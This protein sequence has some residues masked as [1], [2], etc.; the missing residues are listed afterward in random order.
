[1]TD[2]PVKKYFAVAVSA[3]VNRPLTYLPPDES[4]QPLIQ[5][6]RVLVPLSGRKITGYILGMVDSAPVGQQ[7][8][9]IYAVLDSEPFFPAEQ[10]SFY[11][12]IA[13]Y[14]HYP[15]GE[16]IKTA[17]PAGLTKKSGRRVMITDAGRKYLH[18]LSER[19]ITGTPWFSGLLHKGE[20]SPHVTGNLWR[21]KERRLLELWV[22]N[23]WITISSELVGGT[24]KA[25]TEICCGL[26]AN[27]DSLEGLKISEQKTLDV[28]HRISAETSSRF[29]PRREITRVYPGAGKGLQS[30]AQKNIIVF[31]EQQV[32]RDPFG[33]CFLESNIPPALTGEQK[34][35]LGAILPAIKEGRFAPFLL[36]GVTG[37]GKTEV[38][39]QAAAFALEQGRTVLVLVPEI[40]LATQLEAHFLARFGTRVALLHSGL[41]SG[42]RFDQWRRIARG[43]ADVV[44]G[45]RSAVFAPLKA[46]GLIIVDEEHDSS[47][48]QDDG[49]RYH[50]RD[51]AVLRASRSGAVVILGSATPSVTSYYHATEGK[52]KLLHLDK[53]IE[54]RPLPDVEV[55]N[56]QSVRTV[57]GRPP[58]F[59]PVLIKNLRENLDRG[60]QSLIFLNRRGFANFMICRDCGQAVEC[61]HCKV[62]LTLHKS[63]NK[64]LC[65][66]CGFSVS[67]K[68]LCV[69]CRSSSLTA[70]GVGT[71]RLEHE[72]TELLPG[73]RIARLDRDTCQ[74]RNDYIRI[75]RTVHKGDVDI[76]LGT[77]MITKG[78]HF[79]NVTLV[80][81][82]LADTGL[83]L[84]DFRAG[85]RTFQLISQ[86]TGRAGRGEK[87]GRVIIQTFQPQ[88]YSIQMARNHDYAG[89]YAR[90]I[91]MRKAL[92]YPPFS[93][94]VNV[95]IEAKDDKYVQ[96]AA[97]RLAN[98]A[99]KFQK[100]SEAEV[101]GPAPAPL[102]RLR[103]RYRWQL[104]IKGKK[105]E[106]LHAFLHRLEREIATLS[107]AGKLWISIDVDPEYMM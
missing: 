38:Y 43:K 3:P 11:K 70:I 76:L 31:A 10:V 15:I 24:A 14:Y 27:I 65:H 13:N 54:D 18:A 5:G 89:M 46:P 104:L 92:A 72:L 35:A 74:K 58:V 81:I 4:D 12:W 9:K 93:R 57:S 39:L 71:E 34:K 83:G 96:D 42:Q 30:L 63:D 20:L 97:A 101:L 6:M 41:S 48:K 107:K 86:V 73:A 75:L 47:Y 23:G 95:K 106:A 2:D 99:R 78:H 16:V 102:T 51:L 59:S 80:G 88:H 60:E 67:G 55:V 33:E 50:A 64:L 79:P 8:K 53:R 49:F 37:S 91:E 21:S 25:K 94:I 87:P 1:M 69:H 103:D 77:Q 19:T 36:H 61:R 52:Y 62:S 56:M 29:V 68:T 82:V 98:L 105:L 32:Y 66:Y 40:A 17:L 85:E 90:E 22:D 44:I 45:A 7:L 28:L 84:P 26:A 100:S